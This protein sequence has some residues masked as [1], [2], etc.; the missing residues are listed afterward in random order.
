MAVVGAGPAGLTCAYQLV[1]KGY[2]V[3]VFGGR[4]RVAGGM[5]AVGIPEY[6]LPRDVLAHE[7]DGIRELGVGIVANKRPGPR[8][9]AR[10]LVP[11]GVSG[12]LPRHRQAHRGRKLRIPGEELPGVHDGLTFLREIALAGDQGTWQHGRVAVIGG[13]KTAVDAA[14]S[15]L[16]LGAKEVTLFYR[17]TR[18]GMPVGAT[19]LAEAEAKGVRIEPLAVP[20]RFEGESRVEGD[21]PVFARHWAN[22][23]RRA[24]AGR[25][26]SPAANSRSR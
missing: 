23:M 9:H 12:H 14:R 20:L 13:G 18:H 10:R 21:A 2:G 15:A 3:T 11:P 17:R 8:G 7:I 19:E 26:R 16:R 6:R 1:K 5:L 25:L 24:T 22:R 4:L